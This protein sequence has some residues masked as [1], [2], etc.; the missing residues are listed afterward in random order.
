MKIHDVQI[1]ATDV[2]AA[3]RFYA[4]T[5]ELPVQFDGDQARVRIGESTLTMIPGPTYHGAHHIAFTIP[6]GSLAAAKEWLSTRVTLQTDGQWHDEFGCAPN[7][8]ARSI[9]FTGPDDAVLELIERNILDNRIDHPFGVGDIRCLSEVGFGVSDVLETQ[10]LI[11]DTLGLLP[12][13]TPGAGFG[14]VG[15]HDGL[16]ILVPSDVTWR[17]EHRV[18]PPAAP[19]VV[20]ADVPAV[21]EIGEYYRIQPAA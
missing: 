5:L 10:A 1:T 19:T 7:W 8:Q 14:P 9:Y 11:H 21:L 4:E 13:G 2:P 16:F 17:P 6:A 15:D 12:F 3:A 18:P 20:T